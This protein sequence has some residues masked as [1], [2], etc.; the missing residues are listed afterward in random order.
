MDNIAQRVRIL[1]T[2]LKLTQEE[3]GE[4][5]HFSTGT[6]KAVEGTGAASPRFLRELEILERDPAVAKMLEQQGI[7]TGG[8]K[9]SQNDNKPPEDFREVKIISWTHAGQA[10][11]YEELPADWQQGIPS[12]CPDPSAFALVIDGD[13]M[14]P[15]HR[16]GD[17]VVLMPSH[18]PMNDDLVVAKLA[19]NGVMFRL[20]NFSGDEEIIMT[21]YNPRHPVL[22]FREEQF[23]WIYPVYSVMRRFIRNRKK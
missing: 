6:V 1:R 12:D 19:D 7:Y 14:E 10:A 9:L 2:V 4:K 5:M 23:Q 8:T 22:K 11:E 20:F 16:T 21:P 18:K 17:I 3:L 15:N 13:S